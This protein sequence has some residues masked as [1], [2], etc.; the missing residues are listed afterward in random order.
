LSMIRHVWR[1]LKTV[2]EDTHWRN[3]EWLVWNETAKKIQ[4]WELGTPGREISGDLN[5]AFSAVGRMTEAKSSSNTKD[6]TKLWS[7][8]WSSAEWEW[9]QA[10]TLLGEPIDG[11]APEPLTSRQYLHTNPKWK[12]ECFC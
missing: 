2:C 8:A 10:D 1:H 6:C 5:S 9:N 4:L 3:R 11:A 12:S 7:A